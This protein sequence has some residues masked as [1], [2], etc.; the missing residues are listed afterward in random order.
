MSIND[1][2]LA[3]E[4]GTRIAYR[5]EGAGTP[6]VLTNGLTTTTI[7]WDHIRPVW[8]RKHE[9]L[10]WDLPGHGRSGPARTPRTATIEAQPQ[11]VAAVMQAAG[12][13]RAHQ[14]GWSTG[15]QIVLE[16][17]KQRPE[18]CQSLVMLL[19]PAGHVLETTR[20]ML[21]GNA[22]AGLVHH[23]PPTVFA[24]MYRVLT[25]PMS[26][27]LGHVIAR[28]TG[29][30]GPMTSADDARRVTDHIATV[31][32]R[33]LQHM[34]YSA[35][36]HSAHDVLARVHIP[37]LIVSGD[38]DPFAPSELVGIPLHAAAPGSELLRLPTGTHTALLEEPVRIA[39]AVEAFL[40]RSA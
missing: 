15:A 3:L 28:R 17:Y 9:V 19:G 32:A 11:I 39:E 5:V 1:R 37:L 16:L 22:I 4:D 38:Q 10:T 33:T 25:K 27:T 30:I 12:V 18:L 29:M 6:L 2:I 24:A 23:I 7:F 31:D 14:V 26:S 34:V 35:H 13:R 40:A 36:T 8:L 21:P 20:L